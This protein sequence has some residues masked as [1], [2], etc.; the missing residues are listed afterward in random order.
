VSAVEEDKTTLK[1][2]EVFI[3][4]A[5]LV[6]NIYVANS[7]TYLARAENVV[8]VLQKSFVLYLVVTKNESDSLALATSR[9][10]EKLEILHEV[11]DI[12]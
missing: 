6:E 1:K 2:I 3:T 4:L 8:Y 5:K 11:R 9:S 10:I 7:N 12:V